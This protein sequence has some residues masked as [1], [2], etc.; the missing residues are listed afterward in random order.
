MTKDLSIVTVATGR[1]LFLA[2]YF[3]RSI[4]KREKSLPIFLIVGPE[5]I[6]RAEQLLELSNCSSG[7]ICL[8]IPRIERLPDDE[9]TQGCARKLVVWD[10]LPDKFSHAIFLDIDTVVIGQLFDEIVKILNITDRLLLARD[11]YV[12]F[13]EKMEEEF[14]VLDRRWI[15]GFDGDGK[16]KY[17]NTGLMVSKREDCVFFEEVLLEWSRFVELTGTNP[18]IWDQNIFNYCLDVGSFSRSWRDVLI[19]DERF[20]ALKE[21]EVCIDLDRSMISLSGQSP[22]LL[23]FNGG[24]LLTKIA[25]RAKS[26]QLFE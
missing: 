18:S 25:R 14:A 21:Y 5:E 6:Q 7:V 12:G 11:N 8:G 2:P 15:P 22:L 9:A 13:K 17:C 4:R 10:V 23:H 19:L 16:R 3:I 1:Y 24:D 20:N 26:I